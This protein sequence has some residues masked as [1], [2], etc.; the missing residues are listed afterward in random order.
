MSDILKVPGATIV[1]SINQWTPGELPNAKKFQNL[2]AAFEAS[3]AVISQVLGPLLDTNPLVKSKDRIISTSSYYK[4]MSNE[5]RANFYVNLSNQILNTFNLSRVIGPHIALNPQYL[6]G[7]SHLKASQGSGYPLATGRK[8]QQLPFPPQINY[9]ASIGG[10][11]GWSLAS[12]KEEAQSSTDKKY[13]IDEAGVFYSSRTFGS[14]SYVKYD[15][16][17]PNNYSYLGAGYNCIP[18]ISILSLEEEART[19]ALDGDYGLVKITHYSSTFDSSTWRVVFPKVIS[20]KD[21]LLSQATKQIAYDEFEPVGRWETE[22]SAK[23]Y[24]LED[25]DFYTESFVD[26][27]LLSLFNKET[28]ETFILNW[29]LDPDADET[30][31]RT[32]LVTGPPNLVTKFYQ[33]DHTTL[34]Q[35]GGSNSRDFFVFA[36]NSTVTEQLAQLSLNYS[37]HK[38]NGVDSY[39]VSHKDLLDA[40]GNKQGLG[41]QTGT[42][43]GLD[44]VTLNRQLAYSNAQDNV[45]PQYLH[46]LG[47]LYGGSQGLYENIG[48]VEKT[49]DLNMMHGDFL[50]YPIESNISGSKPYKYASSG[51]YAT[52]HS[53]GNDQEK[54]YWD[55]ITNL[56]EGIAGDI[57]GTFPDYRTHA[58]IFGWPNVFDQV[59]GEPYTTYNLGATKL[60][61]EPWNFLT[62]TEYDNTG[63]KWSLSRHGFIPGNATGLS[64]SSRRRG[65]NINWGN[66]FFGYRE[67]IFGGLLLGTVNTEASAFFRTSE[68][69]VIST[70]NDES[71]TNTNSSIKNGYTYRDGV[72]IRAVKGA[73]VWISAGGES[74]IYTDE[75]KS[76]NG[77]ASVIA[78]EASR[79]AWYDAAEFNAG[80]LKTHIALTDKFSAGSGIF[81]SPSLNTDKTIPWAVSGNTTHNINAIWNGSTILS[82]QADGAILDVFALAKDYNYS[83]GGA[84]DLEIGQDSSLTGWVYGRPYVR[85]T[86][87]VNFCASASVEGLDPDYYFGFRR[88]EDSSDWGPTTIILQ[89]VDKEYIH[90]EFRFWGK[91]N[92]ENFSASSNEEGNTVGGNLNLLYNF[93]R[94]YQRHGRNFIWS[95]ANLHGKPPSLEG[96]TINS[97]WANS[98]AVALGSSTTESYGSAIRQASFIEAFQ[99]F[100]SDPMQPYMAEYV[101]PFKVR[102]PLESGA[103]LYTDFHNRNIVI[104]DT[105]I[106]LEGEPAADYYSS[107]NHLYGKF[108]YNYSLQN[109]KSLGLDAIIKG[110]EEILL[111]NSGSDPLNILGNSINIFPKSLVSYSVDLQYYAGVVYPGTGANSRLTTAGDPHTPDTSWNYGRILSGSTIMISAEDANINT[112]VSLAGTNNKLGVVR[113]GNESNFNT[114][115]VGA[116][117]Y[118]LLPYGSYLATIKAEK[119]YMSDSSNFPLFTAKYPSVGNENVFALVLNIISTNANAGSQNPFVPYRVYS[120]TA[121]GSVIEIDPADVTGSSGIAVELNGIIKFKFIRASSGL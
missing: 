81:L 20:V 112:T 50:F 85:G 38:H 68:F 113:S 22:T 117:N 108:A 90:R 77:K 46:K 52:A 42:E 110:S 111:E 72:C 37:K 53:A 49:L 19:S 10:E 55:L 9:T 67:D 106:T 115:L 103:D 47:F 2:F 39:K 54:I 34:L 11:T 86:Y 16:Y 62:D 100:R 21:P 66:L 14:S 45:H 35:G 43:G 87:G 57:A 41:V 79:P 48:N 105:D 109:K 118:Q 5:D 104:T 58:M 25:S 8:V 73:N 60:Y 89:D 101:M 4:T 3:F 70:G 56:E 30:V 97:V 80:N 15:L 33:N 36:I 32:Y 51:A 92:S 75:D 95:N 64:G 83:A 74:E 7:S 71:G 96:A 102:I 98:K 94:D 65:L 26:K 114:A 121:Y 76:G 40:E 119:E 84:I 29:Q 44:F 99:G 69:N 93:G 18:D 12:S 116:N 78:I 23:W 82:P 63:N 91:Q 24:T 120:T 31:K 27:N 61:Y 13:F 6:P 28:G 17:V 88:K 59:V 107:Q 1:S